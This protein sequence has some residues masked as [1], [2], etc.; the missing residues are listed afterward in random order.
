VDVVYS[1]GSGSHW[2][3]NELR[4]S[5]RSLVKYFPGLGN[6]Y[7]IGKRPEWIRNAVHVKAN[8]LPGTD[9]KE[10]N[11]MNKILIACNLPVLS[12]Q[13]LF[14]NDDHFLL[15]PWQTVPFYY[16][17]HLEN[18][19]AARKNHDA[20]YQ[21]LDNTLGV[22]KGRHD[23]KNFD[24]HCPI[25]YDKSYF[26]QVMAAYDW[27]VNFGYVIKSLYCNTLGVKGQVMTDLKINGRHSCSKLEQLTIGRKFFSIG[28]SAIGPELTTYLSYLYPEKS[29]F[30]S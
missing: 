21:S 18:T 15:Q 1:L 26:P 16:E 11:I 4:Y 9:R 7:I 3:D 10:F 28:D 17:K 14:I 19:L 8:D 22:L 30:E 13:F 6:V 5:L 20:Y 29:K 24:I 12:R 25:V 23:T 27:T 2:Q